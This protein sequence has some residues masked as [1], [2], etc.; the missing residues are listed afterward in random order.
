MGYQLF[1]RVGGPG[2]GS[3]K[4]MVRSDLAC[5]IILGGEFLVS[6]SST[7]TSMMSSS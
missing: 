2:P 1:T 7:S 4:C 5:D 3:S 6:I